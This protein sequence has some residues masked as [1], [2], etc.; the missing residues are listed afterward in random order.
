MLKRKTKIALIKILSLFSVIRG[1]NIWMI[2]LAQ[3]LAAIFIL[4]DYLPYKNVLFDLN[5]FMIVSASALAIA[6]GYIINNF[7]DAEKDSVNKPI[8]S[9]IDRLVSQNTKLSVYF[10][11]NF[12]SVIAASYVSFRA[13]V[14]FSLYI[15]WIWFYSH[16]IKRILVLGNI[17]SSVMAVVPFF[18]VFVYYRN[19][20]VGIFVH[21]SF[22][23]LLILMRE[24]IK[25]LE[26]LKGDLLNDYSTIPVVYGEKISKYIITI[27]AIITIVPAFLL[28][29]SFDIGYMEYYFY[30]AIIVLVL[31]CVL[32]WKAREKKGYLILHNLIKLLILLGVFSILLIDVNLVINRF[33]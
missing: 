19:F 8:K 23:F 12:L 26:N 7:Y 13:V 16:K 30:L 21:A 24:L 9:K 4:G 10:V 6:G 2:T 5:L 25:D 14:F 31:F 15:F 11:L 18:A 28:I 29:S 20:D 1:Y 33:L 3:Y 32:L 27:C 17:V 22:L